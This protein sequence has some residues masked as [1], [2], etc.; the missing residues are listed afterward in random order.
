MKS[1][2]I[3]DVIFGIFID[4]LAIF[5]FINTIGIPVNAS[6][7]PRIVISILFIFG[8]LLIILNLKKHKSAKDGN[9]PAGLALSDLE[10]PG[11][12]IAMIIVYMVLINVL[13]FFSA[14][15]IY[16]IGFMNFM[17]VSS[18]KIKIPVTLGFLLFIF[19]LFVYQLNVVLPRGFLY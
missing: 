5:A 12:A 8:T 17:R 11:K 19:V 14:T 2:L 7:F 10:S 16:L 4:V 18:W 13:G 6:F 1:S 15:A 3:Q 9:L